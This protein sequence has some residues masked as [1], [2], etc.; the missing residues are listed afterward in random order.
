MQFE[1]R[2]HRSEQPWRYSDLDRRQRE[3]FQ[4]IQEN[5]TSVFTLLSEVAPVITFG[6]RASPSDLTL[7]MSSLTQRG[8]EVYETD[9]GG[10][11]TYH[12]P[13]QWVVFVVGALEQLTGDRKGVRLAVE[14][15]L[16][17]GVSVFAEFGV[18]AKVREGAETG[19]WVQGKKVGA[20]GVRIDD[21]VLLHGL[22]LNIFPTA[23]SFVGIKP[24][25]LD[26]PVGFL[27]EF[28]RNQGCEPQ[29]LMVLSKAAI[30]REVKA[31]FS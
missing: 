17:V 20:V 25:G 3:C 11:A 23:E 22:S 27:N 28:V 12:G 30:E 13:G 21:G 19:I 2:Q 9:R 7:P 18:L 15:L 14:R 16:Q 1:V 8:I 31:L 4:F 6:R 26:A 10:L 29:A 24:C 5:P